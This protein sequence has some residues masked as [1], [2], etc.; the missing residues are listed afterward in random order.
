M[1]THGGR[2]DGLLMCAALASLALIVAACGSGGTSTAPSAPVAAVT[3]VPESADVV[4]RGTVQLTAAT[5]DASGRVVHGRAVTWASS[6]PD[7]AMVSA[8]GL[9]TAVL[10][11]STTITVTCEGAR[12]R[13]VVV[14]FLP[15]GV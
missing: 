14:V 1:R 8:T 3:I 7:V 4:V 10:R 6:H 2:R 5:W 15:M 9:I 11:G 12:G 13:A